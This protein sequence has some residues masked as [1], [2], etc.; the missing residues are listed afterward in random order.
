M[1]FNTYPNDP[2]VTIAIVGYGKRDENIVNKAQGE[3]YDGQPVDYNIENERDGRHF[4]LSAYPLIVGSMEVILKSAARRGLAD[5]DI[6]ILAS[7]EYF[8]DEDNGYIVLKHP[9]KTG[10]Q[11]RVKY[12]ATFDVNNV[13]LFSS[14]DLDLIRTLYGTSS[15]LNSISLGAEIAF[16]GG[17]THIVAVMAEEL[18]VDPDWTLSYEALM[19]EEAYYIV[20]MVPQS[21]DIQAYSNVVAKGFQFVNQASATAN[22]NESVLVVGETTGLTSAEAQELFGDSE[23]VLFSRPKEVQRVVE[24]QLEILDGRYLAP[25]LA[26]ALAKKSLAFPVTN[27][28]VAGLLVPREYKKDVIELE[29]IAKQGATYFLPIN[30]GSRITRAVTTSLSRNAVLE[31]PS[32]TRTKDFLI[33]SLRKRIQSRFVGKTIFTTIRKEALQFTTDFLKNQIGTTITKFENVR[34]VQDQLEP[35]QLN[36]SFDVEP[37]FPLIFIN[38]SFGTQLL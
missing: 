19:K 26:G 12:I 17:A 4:K 16:L 31:E 13:R 35:R 3:G 37:I 8:V 7:T 29:V 21:E 23:R 14:S 24:G 25:A 11:L 2:T 36:V 9:L 34:V 15:I 32:I 22:R 5:D 38:V 10:E 33:M 1:A 20:P 27:E 30:A 18:T 6:D 28:E